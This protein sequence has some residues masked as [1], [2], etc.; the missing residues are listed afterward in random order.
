MPKLGDQSASQSYPLELK[1]AS[2]TAVSAGLMAEREEQTDRVSG[3]TIDLCLLSVIISNL[4]NEA[5]HTFSLRL[6]PQVI[7]WLGVAMETQVIPAHF[8]SA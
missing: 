7:H 1:G 2:A 6:I 3:L 8:G 5:L 4:T